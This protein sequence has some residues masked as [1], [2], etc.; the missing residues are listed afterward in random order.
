MISNG[1]DVLVLDAVDVRAVRLTVVSAAR[2]HIPVVSY[3]R[4]A[5]GPVAGFVADSAA[6]VGRLQARELLTAL[7]RRAAGADVVWLEGP[8]TAGMV[9]D[10]QAAALSVLRGRVRSITMYDTPQFDP[11][12]AY[13]RAAAA[14]AG[15]GAR[16]VDAVY[17][18]NDVLAAGAISALRAAHVTP[19]PPVVGQDAELTAVQ[20]IISGLQYGS[21]YKLV[22]HEADTAAEMAATLARGERLDGMARSRV[23]NGT[24]RDIPTVRIGAVPVTARTVATAV[25]RDGVYPVGQICTAPYRTACVR[26]GLLAAGR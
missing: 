1:A 4:L 20:R 18:A 12:D 3:D 10:R 14:V 24:V 2:A 5:D 9:G 25:V 16:H 26:A 6:L 22:R 13:A 15:L 21:V 8:P 7:G 19:L 17:A 11:S 23:D